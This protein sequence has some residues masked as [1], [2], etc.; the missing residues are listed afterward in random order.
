M[1]RRSSASWLLLAWLLLIVYASLY[2]FLPWTWPP[3]QRLTDLLALPWP[4]RLFLYDVAFNLVGY[5]PL[6]LLSYAA[7]LRSGRGLRAALW[8]SLLPGPLLSF[9]MEV[10][11]NFLPGRVPSLSDWFFNSLGAWLGVLLALVLDA[12]GAL[13]RWQD[14]RDDWLEPHSAG[15]MALLALW[16]MA[17]LF[18]APVPLGLGQWLPHLED[19]ALDALEGTPWL[20]SWFDA[21]EPVLRALP[22][23][24]EALATALGLLGP[25]LLAMV[26]VRRGWQRLAVILGVALLGM[27]VTTLS[28][29]L[30]F[31]P[32]RA[33]AWISPPTWPGL[34]I[35]GVL[36]LLAVPLPRRVIAALGLLVL[37]S[38]IALV[39][40]APADPYLSLS[41]QAW[42]QGRFINLYGMAQWLGWVW[43]FAA[44]LWLLGLAGRRQL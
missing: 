40:H 42:E 3:G 2:P 32:A 29:A 30:N 25:A 6:G 27:A 5:A 31:G 8:A 24:F 7:M 10:L 41:L 44:L 21:D 17:L 12:L 36:A 37:A 20:L 23:G 14:W 34:A 16:P 19:L 13:R 26:I 18:P 35:G 33:W 22:P 28:T 38:L 11:Q 43:P 4:R 1:A 15:A 9:M 39:T